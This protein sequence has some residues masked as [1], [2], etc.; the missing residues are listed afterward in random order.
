MIFVISNERHTLAASLYK[1]KWEYAF[2]P[3]LFA[4]WWKRLWLPSERNLLCLL[5]F[6]QI[7][8]SLSGSAFVE[9]ASWGPKHDS[10]PKWWL[11]ATHC[12]TVTAQAKLTPDPS[13]FCYLS[14]W[15]YTFSFVQG[16]ASV[17]STMQ[18]TQ[19]QKLGNNHFQQAT[20]YKS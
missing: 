17:W 10:H 7:I 2:F 18:H 5:I 20:W 8:H 13:P 4:S 16:L 19:Q 3:F 14:Y 11:H 6:S 1:E 12:F 9:M 15:A